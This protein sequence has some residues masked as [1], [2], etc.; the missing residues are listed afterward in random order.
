MARHS[1]PLSTAT[2]AD[3]AG[4]LVSDGVFVA[5]EAASSGRRTISLKSVTDDLKLIYGAGRFGTPG[6]ML[7]LRNF[8]PTDIEAALQVL[9]EHGS[10]YLYNLARALNVSARLWTESYPRAPRT[11]PQKPQRIRFPAERL[12]SMPTEFY[13]VGNSGDRDPLERYLKFHQVLEFYLPRAK[14]TYAAA[15]GLPVNQVR[16]PSGTQLSRERGQMQ[17]LLDMAITPIQMAGYL[18]GSGALSVLSDSNLISDASVLP[19]DGAG[20]PVAGFDYRTPVAERIYDIRCRIVHTKDPSAAT[21]PPPIL[22]GSREARDLRT[23]I[24]LVRF[25]AE[26]VLK[27]WATSLT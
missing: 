27:H 23:D 17:A 1:R 13:L 24:R 3:V 25:V 22:P 7:E 19:Q 14:Q 4:L 12:D 8:T 6:I 2:M 15:A 26:R 20:N 18:R 21:I 16:L 10:S 11:N 9:E 5:S